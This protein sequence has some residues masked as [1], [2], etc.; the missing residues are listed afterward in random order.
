MFLMTLL[1]LAFLLLTF[2][3]V[4]LVTRPTAAERTIDGRIASLNGL[5]ADNV[6]VM[7]DTPELVKI[8]RLSRI[9]WLDDL[10][11][12]WNVAQRVRLLIA[13][14]ESAWTVPGFLVGTLVLAGIGYGVGVYALAN[15]LIALVISGAFAAAPYLILR[16]R[17]KQRLKNFSRHLPEA[18]DLMSRALRAGHSVT[19]AIEIVGEECPEPVRTEFREVYRQQNFGLPAREALVQLAKRI[20]LPELNFVVTAMLL[21]KETGGNLVE[22]LERTTA[23]IRERLRIEG[24][25]RIYTAQG[26]LTGW[27]LSLLPIAM[28]FLLSLAN[29]GYTRVLIEDPTG[30]KLVYTGLGLML[31]GGLAI[32]KIVNV[33]V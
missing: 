11:Q 23:V 1:F 27:I 19:A 6:L 5:R 8:D 14:A 2:T 13:Q 18:I 25:I 4:V 20:P 26:R 16:Y 12:R 7:G 15:A 28:F 32:R 24:E 29:R 33:K 30:R 10:L 17:R 21:Q 22:V 9:D 31:V 3:V